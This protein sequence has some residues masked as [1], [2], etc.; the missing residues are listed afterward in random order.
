M[1][2]RINSSLWL[3]QTALFVGGVLVALLLCGCNP[4]YVIRAAYEQSKILASREDIADVLENPNTPPELRKKLQVVTDARRF[5]IELGLKPKNSFTQFA[6]VDGSAVAWVVSAAPKDRFELY[7]WWFPFVGS[8]P[9]KGFFDKDDA[10]DAA[11]DLSAEGY[12]TW[13]RGTEAFSTL[14][15]FDDPVLSTTLR[16][17]PEQIANTVLHESLHTTLWVQ[18]RVDFNE[19]LANFVGMQGSL[20]FF[21]HLRDQ[22]NSAE[23]QVPAPLSSC[24]TIHA[25]QVN[26]C[27]YGYHREITISRSIETLM[28]ELRSL[29][30]SELSLGE[31]LLRR[32]EIFDHHIRPLKQEFPELQILSEINNAELLQLELYLKDLERFAARFTAMGSDWPTFLS[33]MH[34][35]AQK[36]EEDPSL[37]PFSLL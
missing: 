1:R 9:Y 15:W 23:V 18:N 7:T 24:Q 10:L 29:Y 13:V 8:I 37:D 30:E 16:R 21:K 33:E 4:L 31:K 6:E 11:K 12:E 27:E 22:C 35:I 25:A 5:G 28:K 17:D 14:G 2:K 36:V 3:Q 26:A 19:S 32:S 20:D 34:A